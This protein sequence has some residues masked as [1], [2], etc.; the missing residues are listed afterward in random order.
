MKFSFRLLTLSFRLP[1][2]STEPV[3]IFVTKY[4]ID[5]HIFISPSY[6][7]MLIIDGTTQMDYR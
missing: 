1:E 7:T 2:A 6:L 5:H 3:T 4:V